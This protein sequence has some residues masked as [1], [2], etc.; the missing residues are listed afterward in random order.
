MTRAAITV[1]GSVN[2]DDSIRMPRLPGPGETVGARSVTTDLGGKGANQAVA[3]VRAGATVRLVGAIGDQES[4]LLLGALHSDGIA[5]AHLARLPGRASGRA[6]VMVDDHSENSITVVPGTN[7]EIPAG[8]IEAACA[9]LTP[10]DIVLLQNEIL[11]ADSRRAASAARSSGAYVIWNA[12]PAPEARDDIIEDLD[13]LLVNEHELAVL[14]ALLHLTEPKL[15]QRIRGVGQGLDADVIC[16]L[17]AAGSASLIKGASTRHEAI[18]VDAMDTT[19]A[20]DT[21]VGYLAAALGSGASPTEQIRSATIAA[22]HTV[23]RPGAAA[24]IPH[25]SELDH[26]PAPVIRTTA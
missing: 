12:A 15:E 2:V 23:T 7:H 6:I 21:Y 4:S 22:V 16:T 20:G 13:L 1:I 19:A 3:A 11:A 14:A 5:T 9:S 24:S 10:G 18:R 8:T 25:L 26:E 17:G